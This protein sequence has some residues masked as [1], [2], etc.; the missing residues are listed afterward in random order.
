LLCCERTN[1]WK[2]CAKGFPD[3]VSRHPNIFF[4]AAA[5]TSDHH[6]RPPYRSSPSIQILFETDAPP[7]V[8]IQPPPPTPLGARTSPRTR[9][10]PEARRRP[11]LRPGPPDG[12]AAENESAAAAAS[13][14]TA[15]AAAA[16]V[17]AAAAGC[18]ADA[19][20]RAGAFDEGL[21]CLQ[22]QSWLIAAAAPAGPSRS[23]Y[24]TAAGAA[25][26]A[27]VVARRRRR[28][29]RCGRGWGWRCTC[30]AGRRRVPCSLA[31]LCLASCFAC[32]LPSSLGTSND[33]ELEKLKKRLQFVVN[34]IDCFVS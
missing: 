6:C 34:C 19:L 18:D 8:L 29:A 5:S 9:P 24:V 33:T 31:R 4:A 10:G 30:W 22:G 32:S 1:P 7:A 16:A 23:D 3:K 25:A 2:K 20:L 27:G 13:A 17:S 26:A 28:R 11:T 21:A 14:A 15:A 12:P